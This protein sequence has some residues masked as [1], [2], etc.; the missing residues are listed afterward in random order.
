MRLGVKPFAFLGR[1]LGWFVLTYAAWVS[2]ASAYTH[3]LAVVTQPFLRLA[4]RATSL[5]PRGTSILFWPQGM[6]V[7]QRPPAVP[8]EW[9]QANL[10]LLLPLMLAT[11]APTWSTKFR[12]LALALALV[13]AW[14]VLDVI[15]AIKFGYATQIDPLSYAGW[16]RYLYAFAANLI[17]FLDTQV[18]PF[19][20]W[21]GI[22]F[23][24]LLGGLR[25]QKVPIMPTT[26]TTP[27][28]K[29]KGA[30][31]PRRGSA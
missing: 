3:L 7:P 13:L 6:Q 31:R 14:Q 17:M 29:K 24:Q 25:L 11:P 19:M 15:I 21:A 10:V 9:I 5:W 27:S 4:D 2:F 28:Q 20:I 1:L 30:A 23:R 26:P 22:H 12:R 16:Q 18:V 8:A